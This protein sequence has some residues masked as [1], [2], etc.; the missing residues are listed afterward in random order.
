MDSYWFD[1]FYAYRRDSK[2]IVAKRFLCDV[3]RYFSCSGRFDLIDPAD[4]FRG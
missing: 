1:S 3:D 4:Y 2:G